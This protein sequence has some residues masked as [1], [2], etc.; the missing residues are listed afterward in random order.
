MICGLVIHSVFLLNSTKL[1]ESLF[2]LT[3]ILFLINTKFGVSE[4][5]G[6]PN[7]QM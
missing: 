3:T 5:I 7:N 4:G 1:I 6:N 2:V